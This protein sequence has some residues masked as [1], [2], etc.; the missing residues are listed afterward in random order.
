LSIYIVL[1][2]VSVGIKISSLVNDSTSIIAKKKQKYKRYIKIK[3][4]KITLDK[5]VIL[6]YNTHTQI[7]RKTILARATTGV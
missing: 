7:F 4:F 5:S 3:N 2:K 6:R 1:K